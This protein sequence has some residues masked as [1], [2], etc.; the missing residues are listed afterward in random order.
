MIDIFR[1]TLYLTF[2]L[3]ALLP[4]YIAAA[5]EK[6]ERPEFDGSYEDGITYTLDDGLMSKEEME[7][8]SR[9]VNDLCIKNPFQNKYLNC[10]C[11]AGEFL[12]E[13]ERLGPVPMQIDILDDMTMSGKTKCA[14]TERIAG[15]SYAEC[16]E[17]SKIFR[18]MEDDHRP[19]CTCLAN[20]FALDFKKKPVAVSTYVSGLKAKAGVFCDQPANRA[21]FNPSIAK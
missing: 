4:S 1:R 20:K 12:L 7:R 18:E 2:F 15:D 16:L 11:L 13:R 3:L 5:Q 14:N 8:E 19:Y 21:S 10:E 17:K 9:Y 6:R